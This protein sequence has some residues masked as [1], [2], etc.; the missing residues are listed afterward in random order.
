MDEA[1]LIRLPQF[2]LTMTEAQLVEWL[3]APGHSV[4]RGDI[5][6]VVETD[7]II[8][9]LLADRD[10]I[11]ADIF[12]AVD[13]TV[14]VG[15]ALARWANDEE[16][17]RQPPSAT[18]P[19]LTV[20]ANTRQ[21][22]VTPPANVPPS[23][24]APA[25]PTRLIASPFARKRA[26]ELNI[27]LSTITGSG[28]NGRIVAA[29][30][31]TA[32][33]L[34]ARRV[35]ASSPERARGRHA[36]ATHAVP[37]NSGVPTV[38]ASAR[39]D[40]TELLWLHEGL[41]TKPGLAH[42][43]MM[44]WVASALGLVIAK[45]ALYRTVLQEGQTQ[46]LPGS[47]IAIEMSHDG[48]SAVAVARDVGAHGLAD[49]ATQIEELRDRTTGAHSSPTDLELAATSLVDL[50]ASG[51]EFLFPA[52]TPGRTTS[53]VIGGRT[54]SFRPRADDTPELRR[55]QNLVLACDARVFNPTT[56]SAMLQAVIDLLADPLRII[57]Q[58]RR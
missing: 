55:E 48:S 30:V 21:P 20:S 9:E 37:M 10:G 49:N 35:H 43:R 33:E 28:P 42:L 46:V 29:D 31:E 11:V 26:R 5:L 27:N 41:V 1:A 53:L 2:G 16:S 38:F 34:D 36:V 4:R 17:V 6:C 40:V 57:A 23:D 15:T 14:P 54:A 56:S 12:V 25:P 47:D 50:S 22:C 51:V 18:A 44:H 52:I 24:D 58:K 32:H 39:A 3:V 13:D 19:E 8:N 7:K 45:Q